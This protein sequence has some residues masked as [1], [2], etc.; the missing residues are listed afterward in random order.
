MPIWPLRVRFWTISQAMSYFIRYI[1]IRIWW[2]ISRVVLLNFTSLFL[3]IY[4][5]TYLFPFPSLRLLISEYAFCRRPTA[6]NDLERS[7]RNRMRVRAIRVHTKTIHVQYWVSETI[8]GAEKSISVD[9]NV[10]H[11]VV[12]M[13]RTSRTIRKSLQRPLSI[14]LI[15]LHVSVAVRRSFL[16]ENNPKTLSVEPKNASQ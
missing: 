14:R 15:V 9:E 12:P 1:L 8:C 4:L 3:F 16:C 6:R 13:N 5:V 10:S 2:E 11:W 7:I